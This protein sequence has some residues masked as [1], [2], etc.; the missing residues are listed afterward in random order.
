MKIPGFYIATDAIYH[1][2]GLFKIGYSS[3]LRSRVH[4][5]TTG[6]PCGFYY[7]WTIEVDNEDLARAIEQHTLRVLAPHRTLNYNKC[8]TEFVC[9]PTPEEI[10]SVARTAN[11][12]GAEYNYKVYPRPP[13]VP[14]AAIEPPV[15]ESPSLPTVEPPPLP[16]AELPSLPE[17]PAVEPQPLPASGCLLPLPSE[18]VPVESE[19][20]Y[21]IEETTETDLQAYKATLPQSQE[22]RPYQEEARLA[23]RQ[24]HAIGP[25]CQLHMACRCG[26][27]YVAYIASQ[28]YNKIV[29]LVP[30]RKLLQQTVAK[31]EVYGY[32]N[33]ILQVG[34]VTGGT[35]NPA[36]V[37]RVLA[38]HEKCFVVS[39]YQ[40]SHILP[41]EFDLSILDEAH[42]ICGK[43]DSANAHV[44]L[45]HAHGKMISMTASPD[46]S[47]YSRSRDNITMADHLRFG[48]VAYEYTMRRGIDAGFINDYELV[49]MHT[50][51][52]PGYFQCVDIAGMIRE[53]MS[54]TYGCLVFV[55]RIAEIDA[56]HALLAEQPFTSLKIHSGMSD[57]DKRAALSAFMRVS[58]AQPTVMI[59]CDMLG[60][61][62]E[63][64]QLPSVF[65]ARPMTSPFKIIQALNR[66]NTKT[67]HKPKS[68]I[69]LPIFGPLPTSTALEEKDFD[70]YRRVAE[71]ANVLQS[72]DP[73]I[74]KIIASR[75]NMIKTSSPFL[76]HRI[77]ETLYHKTWECA[78]GKKKATLYSFGSVPWDVFYPQL[79]DMV[80]VCQRYP[81]ASDSF[82]GDICF[83]KSF[84]PCLNQYI[85]EYDNFVAGR[86]SVINAS[87]AAQLKALPYWGI[88]HETPYPVELMLRVLEDYVKEH[89]EMPLIGIG[90]EE[91][92]GLGANYHQRLSGYLRII[93][94]HD[95][96][97]K[98]NVSDHEAA[99]LD[100]ILGGAGMRW[101]KIRD[102]KG[103]VVKGSEPTCIQKASARLKELR[104]A[105]HPIVDQLFPD[106]GK[107]W[108]KKNIP[109]KVYEERFKPLDTISLPPLGSLS[110][111]QSAPCG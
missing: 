97:S 73:N 19:G 59:N 103:I 2:H 15:V 22:C 105:R 39:T 43:K 101:R 69:F 104:K 8:L 50:P 107:P 102:D 94:N 21:I 23:V 10:L 53:I 87:Q 9:G 32:P 36:E 109:K 45:N 12:P 81:C 16:T 63:C 3:D 33:F 56:V 77:R 37:R 51:C 46:M 4:D 58:P 44:L 98:C 90:Q 65:F 1:S 66:A 86:P 70:R 88:Y 71:I 61:G 7:I 48:P 89:R 31:L 110:L 111:Q 64:P 35:T 28:D 47:R 67:E 11:I 17:L 38:A 78:Q 54:E 84:R 75:R 74:F 14:R 5:Y 52:E 13:T 25:R 40:S 42:T 26:K 34:S 55:S 108:Y 72:H 95:G 83:T 24:A 60:V 76:D 30:G 99:R 85:K 93:N 20:E 92:I 41:D 68:K 96:W 80:D 57:K 49:A 6:S 79:K 91:H 27:T 18:Q 29:M 82:D 62:Y 100:A 106:L